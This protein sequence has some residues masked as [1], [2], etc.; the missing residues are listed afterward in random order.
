MQRYLLLMIDFHSFCFNLSYNLLM[1]EESF[2]EINGLFIC[3]VFK[4]VALN[5]FK[6]LAQHEIPLPELQLKDF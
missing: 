3:W 2:V 5:A 1:V 6:C 4:C